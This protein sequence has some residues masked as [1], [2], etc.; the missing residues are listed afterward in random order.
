M[1]R[2]CPR[3]AA[4][5]VVAQPLGGTGRAWFSNCSQLVC[6]SQWRTFRARPWLWPGSRY[7]GGPYRFYFCFDLRRNWFVG[8][9]SVIGVLSAFSVLWLKDRRE[10]DRPKPGFDG[11]YITAVGI[12]GFLRC[13]RS[14]E[15]NTL[16]RYD[17]AVRKFRVDID[18]GKYVP[19]RNCD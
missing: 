16:K 9:N 5:R 11:R 18:R 8:R 15:R 17:S 7:S 14:F 12:P 2:I 4:Y 13:W 19:V 1:A 3:P 10:T 6:G